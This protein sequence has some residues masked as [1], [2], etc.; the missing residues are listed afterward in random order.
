MYPKQSRRTLGYLAVSFM[1]TIGAINLTWR[2]L[3]GQNPE[4]PSKPQYETPR[5]RTTIRR[6]PQNWLENSHLTQANPQPVQT[7]SPPA[8]QNAA[9]PVVHKSTAGELM[10]Q[11]DSD[12]TNVADPHLLA[13]RENRA[14][15]S[16][17]SAPPAN[18]PTKFGNGDFERTDG[19]YQPGIEVLNFDARL[20]LRNEQIAL[21]AITDHRSYQ[22][23]FNHSNQASFTPLPLEAK[24]SDIGLMPESHVAGHVIH[25]LSDRFGVEY[26]DSTHTLKHRR[27]NVR[28]LLS[29]SLLQVI[30]MNQ[31][32]AAAAS[33]RSF[34]DLK[35]TRG[36]L[37]W[38]NGNPVYRVTQVLFHKD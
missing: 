2:Q 15:D 10:G 28:Y 8:S 20:W 1:V 18:M 23:T 5:I 4:L 29:H 30:R 13:N 32:S 12:Q 31:E 19:E 26:G 7:Q 24:W 36:T 16:V 17:F 38:A 35:A 37:D 3:D 22:I 9:K 6:Q 27:V 34:Q 33:D 14:T 25:R 21:V 11:M